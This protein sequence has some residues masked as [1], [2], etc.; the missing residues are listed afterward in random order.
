M[1]VVKK[2]GDN[3]PARLTGLS[4]SFGWAL[5]G[6]IESLVLDAESGIEPYGSEAGGNIAGR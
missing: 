4:N 2:H 5:G 3:E 1:G 6:H